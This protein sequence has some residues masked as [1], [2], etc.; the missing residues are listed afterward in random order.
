MNERTRRDRA[1]A[2]W[3]LG[4]LTVAL[5]LSIVSMGAQGRRGGT[6]TT[7]PI[8]QVRAALA[9]GDVSM[10]RDLAANAPGGPA[11]RAL[12]TAL[13]EIFEGKD[14]DARARL[15]P[16]VAANPLGDAALELGLLEVRTGH[17]DE[18]R[19]LLNALASVRTFS[20]PDDYLRLARAARGNREYLLANDAFQRVA[21]VPRADIQT[22]W[23]DLFLE[24]H[25]PGDAATNYR[26]A[27]ELDKRW[28]PA[29]VGLGRALADDDP[30]QS[31]RAFD[32]A[33]AIAPDDPDLWLAT[34]EQA[35][36]ANDIPA[37]AQA[38]DGLA[39]VKPGSLQEA[40]LRAA[41]AY[42]REGLAGADTAAARVHDLNPE[43]ALGYRAAAEQAAR[44]YRFDDAAAL[45]RKATAIDAEDP[46]AFF[47]LGLDLLRAGEEADART[48]LETSWNLDKSSPLTK[49]LL[50]LLDDL[51]TFTVV[52]HGP[53]IF[54]FAPDEAAVLEAYALPL[55]DEAYR[56][57]TERYGF[58]PKGPILI[59]VFPRHDDFAVRTFGL[60]GLYG[61]LGACFGR[62]IGMDSPRAR[63]PGDF[64]WQATLWHELAHVFT[65]Q[66]SD[67]RVPRWLTEGISVY[68]EHRRNP[69]WGRE[70]T[71][72]YARALN[73]GQTFG[74]KKLPD[75][76]KHPETLAMAYFEASLVVEH[77]VDLN[78]E[79]GLRTLLLAYKN[80]ATDTDAFSRAFGKSADDVEASFQA[81][82]QKQ[83]GALAAAMGDPPRQVDANDVDGLRAR[84]EAA[85]GNFV[86]QLTYGQALFR[87]QDLAGARAPLE[88]AAQ[89][90]PEASGDTSPHMLLAAIAKQDGDTT[91]ARREL[92]ALLTYDHTNVVAA[93]ELAQ[94]ATDAKATD[95][96][97]FALRLVADLDPFDA[98]TH[99][100]LAQRLMARGEY[101][102]AAVELQAT[103]AL[104]PANPAE[105]HADLAE[106]YL[107]MNKR[108]DA[109]RE[110]LAALEVA[111]TFA[112]AQ[113][114][115]LQASAR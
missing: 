2:W 10:A 6:T 104:G 56:Q 79:S 113:D 64:S 15:Q 19:R 27:L 112:R 20:T 30:E 14:T 74:V 39:R 11:R 58:T 65:L 59:E 4:L 23:G 49:N 103:L 43:S 1:P 18:G 84:A 34:A 44:D 91:G 57:Y 114:L 41:V 107:K 7:D 72:Q 52:P 8:S 22:E 92:R 32:A 78:G 53:F 77:L 70:L 9:H 37:A 100:R 97:D 29:I 17:R 110:A 109:K 13:V 46:L 40:A 61:A 99:T 82:V 55:A 16:I 26:K 87:M 63:P 106:V 31:R 115:L 3:R 66:L 93:R 86:S 5:G 33:K 24:R 36:D 28:V 76:F 45:A 111:P 21:D 68:E 50:Q 94:L 80:G 105:A 101:A 102:P 71:L 88:R 81:F 62:V 42:K 60:P 47:D 69:A 73:K 35:L 51:D 108:D 83:Y 75:A 89:L 95:D 85:P 98:D 96:E 90:A 67:Y 12:A 38:L 54:K 25:Q 48:A